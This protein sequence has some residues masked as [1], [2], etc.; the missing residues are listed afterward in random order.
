[1]EQAS[2]HRVLTRADRWTDLPSRCFGSVRWVVMIMSEG[3]VG[4][5]D[6][7]SE[8]CR[9]CGGE[10]KRPLAIGGG[11]AI[12]VP[13]RN[14]GLEPGSLATIRSRATVIWI[15]RSVVARRI[16]ETRTRSG[17]DNESDHIDVIR[18]NACAI[19]K[20]TFRPVRSRRQ[21]SGISGG[22]QCNSCRGLHG[23]PEIFHSPAPV[24]P[25]RLKR[26]PCRVPR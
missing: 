15:C 4:V 24:P 22:R 13:E 26:P 8:V 9:M 12:H 16:G 19:K 25:A 10:F 6:I 21:C 18:P 3:W 11:N 5:S 17:P 20:I 14:A 23:R 1:M 7:L 2:I